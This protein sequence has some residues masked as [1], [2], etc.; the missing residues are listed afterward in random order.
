MTDSKL[1]GYLKDWT[2]R[3]ELAER[4][5]PLTGSLY[6]SRGVVV[7]IC[8]V[9]L[10]HKNPVQ[11]IKAHR[12]MRKQNGKELSLADSLEALETMHGMSLAPVRVDLGK[13]VTRYQQSGAEG[14][15]SAFVKS[16]LA[17]YA[18]GPTALRDAPQDVVLYGFGRIGR[19]LAR[20]L[21]D[22]T[23]AGNKFRLRAVVV[24]KQIEGDIVKRASLLRRDSVHG[25]FM[26]SIEVL[27]DESAMVVNGNY[28]KFIYAN[29]PESID[30]TAHG[31]H[32][33]IVIDNTGAWRD[34]A[35][36]GR[37]LEA[38]GV[39][40]VLLTAPG[41]GD[42][43]NI[44]YGVNHEV[45]S[46]DERII[47][48]ASCTTNAIV[49]VLKAV[50]DRYGIASGHVETIHSYTNDQNLI[51]NFH[52]KE[53]R[54]RSA[55]LNMV[56]T[57]TGAASAIAKALPEL[58]GKITG[59]AIR[60]PT[61]NVSLAMLNLVLTKETSKEELNDFLRRT[62]MDSPLTSQIDF[63]ASP[64]VVSTDLVGNSHATIVD[65][66]ATIVHGNRCTLYAWYDNEYGYSCQVMRLF[67][68]VAGILPPSYVA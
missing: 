64:D 11:I 41:K 20:I 45:L 13:L 31:I 53:R 33:A 4:I 25:T 27:E 60:V 22:K 56:I 8:G 28:I 62:A 10:V 58:A 59:N 9:S 14:G 3:E 32:D 46:P 40:K 1:S 39:S 6:R 30:Y 18:D 47:S 12:Y 57:E 36:L 50:N 5:L 49:P 35:G 42:I 38:K 24:R 34:R 17:P 67:Q 63:T 51:D 66:T 68:Y 23:G 7:T 16:E 19:I 48:A 65:S 2:S 15:L 44:V 54:G 21:V 26:G 37:H 43:P 29:A 55:A 52:K 61:P